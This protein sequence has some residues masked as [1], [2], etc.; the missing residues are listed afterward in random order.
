M[1]STV[2]NLNN[3]FIVPGYYRP[4]YTATKNSGN[5]DVVVD[6]EILTIIGTPPGITPE[7]GSVTV[8]AEVVDDQGTPRG[9]PLLDTF[10]VNV[11]EADTNPVRT[12]PIPDQLFR[13][14]SSGF[15]NFT[16]DLSMHF[17]P[18]PQAGDILSYAITGSIAGVTFSVVGNILTVTVESTALFLTSPVPIT[19]TATNAFNNTV[20]DTF[21]VTLD[22]G[23]TLFA[24]LPPIVMINSVQ[25]IL[26]G[27][28]T[29][30]SATLSGGRYDTLSYA[31]SITQGAAAGTLTNET[32]PIPTYT[33][34]NNV[35]DQPVTVQLIV[36]AHGTGVNAED[37]SS[38]V[39]DT[40][41]VSFIVLDHIDAEVPTIVINDV[42]DIEASGSRQ[43]S[44]VLSDGHYDRLEYLWS[45]TVGQT[46][47]T[48]TNETT[49][50]PTFTA[51]SLASD[52]PVT[53]RLQITAY[54]DG[55][56]ADAGSSAT[57]ADIEA[58]IVLARGLFER[59][60]LQDF[61]TLS[62][63]GNN[64]PFGMWSD[65]TTMWVNDDDDDKIY[66]YNV[67]TK[68]HVPTQDFNNLDS[69]GISR[70][71]GIWSDGTTMWVSDTVNRT[72]YAYNLLTKA[73]DTSKDFNL[74]T[75]N[76]N[77]RGIWSDGTTMWVVDAD[78]DKIYAYVLATGV[79]DSS[80]DF[81]TLLS[82]INLGPSD[83]WS[84]GTTM[85]VTNSGGGDFNKIFAYNLST[86]ARD[87]SK[88][89]NTLV[90]AGNNNP[91]G[92]W[93]NGTTMWVSDT[94]DDKL[95][96]YDIEH[97]G[98]LITPFARNATKDFNTLVGAG[99][100]T[101]VGIW[102]DGTT[103]WVSDFSDIDIYAYNLATGARDP[104]KEFSNVGSF[105][106]GIRGIWSDG[107]TMWVVD[108]G[109]PKIFA[110]NLLTKA[111]DP[112]KDISTLAGAGNTSPSG[113][114]SD[115]ITMWVSDTAGGG[116]IYAYNLATKARDESKEFSNVSSDDDT[117]Q[118]IWSDGTT[119]WVVDTA[120]P[121]IFAYNLVTK[122][123]NATKD[124]NTLVGAGN[125]T[126]VGI[127]SDGTT[128]WVVDTVDDKLYA[129]NMP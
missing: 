73:R 35:A 69:D 125:T 65:G 85:W 113:I 87:P 34:G 12:I 114:W 119:M 74:H 53:V 57:A 21:N 15:R 124:F 64:S 122:A 27:A 47:G 1:G 116:K 78:D 117:I 33:A 102:S 22:D 67:V 28:S 11:T 23:M 41:T 111:R 38:A 37:G 10:Q 42:V 101:P 58:F 128:M 20:E 49:P 79:R 30:L 92:I 3:Y 93:S 82:A 91:H 16:I 29:M 59:H 51:S 89:F 106:D 26:D 129:Y 45:I 9:V 70:A 84:D 46:A 126:P 103:M 7:G 60:P 43:L 50:T 90:A 94:D 39:A 48:L 97:L 62:T 61:N 127:W 66:A 56:D 4:R 75:S 120:D 63:I 31:W 96:A 123:R 109:D 32:M 2:I 40:A 17:S 121:K 80:K 98:D 8:T 77:S 68:A 95:Y 6:G 52:T 19:I 104:D 88:D 76:A 36:T 54:G 18:S 14:P 83:I 105:D 71:R 24:A 112:S 107:I 13:I 25:D 99:N 5:F 100:T 44:A 108:T 115:G 110:Y 81:N 55:I 72:V 118:G 86:K